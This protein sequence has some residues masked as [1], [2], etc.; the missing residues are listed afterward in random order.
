LSTPHFTSNQTTNVFGAGLALLLV[1]DTRGSV[2]HR[3][4]KMA[5]GVGRQN[6][7]HR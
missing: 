2:E 1:H 5:F 4:R 7:D 6:A 3:F